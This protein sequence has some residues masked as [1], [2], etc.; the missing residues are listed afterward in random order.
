MHYDAFQVIPPNPFGLSLL[1]RNVNV[2]V[3]VKNGNSSIKGSGELCEF[4]K[5]ISQKLESSYKRLR[6]LT[7]QMHFFW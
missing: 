5:D 7:D 4:D 2:E 1:N 3:I 6:Y